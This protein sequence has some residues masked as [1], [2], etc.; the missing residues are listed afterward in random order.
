MWIV[1]LKEIRELRRNRKT[2]IFTILMPIFIMPLLTVGFG[3]LAA[4]LQHDAEHAEL[5]Y[6]I[7][8]QQNSPVLSE[9]FAQEKSFR[10]VKLDDVKFIK[11]AIADDRI[12]FALVI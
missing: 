7:F 2:L 10:E 4:T 3:T 6:V 5:R 1:Y 9:L 12:K 11:A 8:G